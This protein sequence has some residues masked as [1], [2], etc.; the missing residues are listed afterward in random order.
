M[1]CLF[2]SYLLNTPYIIPVRTSQRTV[3]IERQVG[4]RMLKEQYVCITGITGNTQ[5]H[6]AQGAEFLV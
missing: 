6:C 4:S 2:T 1:V 5:T 3:S